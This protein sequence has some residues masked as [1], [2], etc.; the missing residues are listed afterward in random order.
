[1]DAYID[2]LEATL[3]DVAR[4][5]HRETAKAPTHSRGRLL[6]LATAGA[7]ALTVVALGLSALLHGGEAGVA[8][9]SALPAFSGPAIDISDR[10]GKLPS[11]MSEGFDL[12][13]ARSFSTS[14]GAGYVVASSDDA[15]VCIVLP[16]P[17]AGYGGT[18]AATDEVLR[19]GLVGERVAPAPDAGHSEV[20]VLQGDA[21]PA[22]VL[23][24]GTGRSRSLDVE[25]GIATAIITR[26]GTLTVAGSDGERRVAVRPFEPQGAIWVQCADGRRVQVQSWRESAE[27]RR[28]AVCASG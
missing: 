7:L 14:K 25:D 12:S 28:A 20:V 11:T 24:D 4:R 10:A 2:A 15:G 18:C 26:A 13:N 16:D 5:Q 21:A 8:R 1:M 17:P 22:P 6:R 23:R 19:R 3:K 27:D 9:A